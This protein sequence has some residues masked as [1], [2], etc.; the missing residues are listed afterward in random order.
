MMDGGTLVAEVP[1]DAYGNYY[2]TQDLGLPDAVIQPVVLDASG[3][4]VNQMPWP[5]ESGSCNQ[6]HTP[7]LR[8]IAP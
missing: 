3:A 5:T 2:T 7:V 6:C 4:V 8:V 1:I